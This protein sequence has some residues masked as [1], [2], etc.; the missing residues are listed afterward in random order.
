MDS[1]PFPSL[2]A[3]LSCLR[4]ENASDGK[5]QA[6]NHSNQNAG[7][8]ASGLIEQHAKQEE[9]DR[10]NDI[11]HCPENTHYGG[12]AAGGHVRKLLRDHNKRGHRQE[13]KCAKHQCRSDCYRRSCGFD[14]QECA[15]CH[16]Q[17]GNND[18]RFSL[19][20]LFGERNCKQCADNATDTQL[21]GLKRVLKKL[22]DAQPDKEE[23]IAKIA[24]QTQGF[25]VISKTDCEALIERITAMLDEAQEENNG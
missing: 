22:K 5:G 9:Y 8:I 19:R 11:S 13:H 18:D 10:L 17:T 3:T 16:D 1:T 20:V 25:K 4:Q 7:R 2:F 15:G 6:Q 23:M 14:H 24:V 12:Q 21:K